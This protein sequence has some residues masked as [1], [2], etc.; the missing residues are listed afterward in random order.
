M[1]APAP[2]LSPLLVTHVSLCRDR[3]SPLV[4]PIFHH[5]PPKNGNHHLGLPFSQRGQMRGVAV[6]ALHITL[7]SLPLLVPAPSSRLFAYAL[8]FGPCDMDVIN[9]ALA[10]AAGSLHSPSQSASSPYS[11]RPRPSPRSMPHVP[12]CAPERFSSSL[13]TRPARRPRAPPGTE[14]TASQPRGSA[15]RPGPALTTG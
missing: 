14:S 11:C 1:V 3:R 2:L 5:G 12:S 8:C 7:R 13:P 15:P 6:L 10:S 9:P 4:R